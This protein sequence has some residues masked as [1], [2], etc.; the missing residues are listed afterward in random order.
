MQMVLFKDNKRFIETKFKNC[1][2]KCIK[3]I[4]GIVGFS[5]YVVRFKVFVI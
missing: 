2:Q 1:Y 4:A 5:G 3:I